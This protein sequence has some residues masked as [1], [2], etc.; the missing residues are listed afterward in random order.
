MGYIDISDP[1]P[2][3]QCFKDL[4]EQRTSLDI[5]LQLVVLQWRSMQ[6]LG[7]L[8]LLDRV[9]KFSKPRRIDAGALGVHHSQLYLRFSESG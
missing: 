6:F 7:I 9:E 1:E 8:K 4:I 3:I 5:H 2:L